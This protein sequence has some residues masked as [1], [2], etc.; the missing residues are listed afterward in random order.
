MGQVLCL[1][2]IIDTVGWHMK[3]AVAHGIITMRG[4][5]ENEIRTFFVICE[6]ISYAWIVAIF[7][8][9]VHVCV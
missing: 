3:A 2:H 5:S 4:R 9:C 1:V 8:E 6:T 7:S